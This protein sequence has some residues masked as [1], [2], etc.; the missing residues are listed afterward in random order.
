MDNITLNNITESCQKYLINSFT[1][2]GLEQLMVIA[3]YCTD[4]QI[5]S[6]VEEL[7]EN[8]RCMLSFLASGGKDEERQATQEKICRKALENLRM[9]HR[10]IRLQTENTQYS[11]AFHELQNQYGAEPEEMLLGKW[12]NNPLS[13][14]QLRLQDHIFSLIWTSPIWNQKDTAQW[15]EFLSR[16]SDFVKIHLIGAVILSAWEYF[17]EEKI[18]LLFLFTDTE[19][20]KLNALSI[21]CLILLAE[22]YNK[23]IQLYP[24]IREQYQNS[25]VIRNIPVVLREKL[26]MIQTLLAIKKE[27]EE[28]EGLSLNM[29]PEKMEKLMN[30]KMENLRHMVEKGLDVNLGNRTELWYKCEFLRGNISHWW[31]PFE[32]SSPVIEGMFID[33][34][35]SFNKQAYKILDM[36]TECDIDRYSMFSYMAK[37]QFKNSFIEKMSEALDNIE[38]ISKEEIIVPYI[39]Y[40]KQAMQSLYRIFSHSPIKSE[41]DNP[42][43]WPQDYWTNK[44]I[45]EHLTEENVLKLCTEMMEAGILDLPVTWLDKLSE[46]S[47]TSYDMLKLKSNCL[48]LNHKYTEAIEPL[49]QMLFLQED[50]EWALNTLQECYGNTD[51]KSQQLEIILKLIDIHPG[52]N[53]YIA[54]AAMV[55]ME[56]KRYEEALKYLF[57]LDY[58]EPDNVRHQASIETCALHLKKFDLA[59]RYNQAVLE[60]RNYDKKYR[61]YLKAGHAYFGMGNWKEAVVRY[62]EYRKLAEE[63]NKSGK[64]K[65]LIDK[66]F[67]K[68]G[69]LL[70]DFGIRLEDI[71]LMLDMMNN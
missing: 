48:F 51:R 69:E 33:K 14:E 28:V 43:H 18:S 23:E 11:K 58:T 42:F 13:D 6:H 10:D 37:A 16:Q 22:K 9:A 4:K 38:E 5:I 52:K 20:L 63:W 68:D 25:T 62:K 15:Y 12:S 36:P 7:S 44:I 54:A 50:D 47:G 31:M 24:Q 64:E 21:T 60:H 57:Q 34:D 26:L 40:M 49:T 30:R 46:T 41:I 65:I 8:Y 29:T 17:D 45:K 56:I 3:R 59:L 35:G 32:K 2:C 67:V 27:Q 55:L 53:I 71:M 61:E 39:D 70:M 19:S 1:S 66:E